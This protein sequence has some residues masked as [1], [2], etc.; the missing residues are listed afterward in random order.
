MP[1]AASVS[2]VAVALRRIDDMHGAIADSEALADERQQHL[3]EL[4]VVV[5]E[6]ARMTTAADFSTGE[7]DF[8]G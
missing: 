4:I 7:T 6:R 8:S 1:A 3:I 2:H 5:K